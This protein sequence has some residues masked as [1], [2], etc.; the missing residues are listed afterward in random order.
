MRARIGSA[1]LALTLGLALLSAPAWGDDVE[2]VDDPLFDEEYPQELGASVPDPI[3]PLNRKFFVFNDKVD[4]YVLRPVTTAYQ[5]VVPAPIRA[6]VRRVFGNVKSPV[7]LVNNLFQLRFHD[8]AETLGSFLVNSTAGIGGIFDWSSKIGIE[9]HPADFGQTLGVFGV[10]SGPYLVIPLLG[11][12]TLR[13][14]VGDVVDRAFDPL[15]YLLGIGNLIFIGGSS[16]FV[17]R[18]ANAE[19]IEALRDSSVDYYAA[20]RSAYTQNR[21]SRIAELRADFCLAK[22]DPEPVAPE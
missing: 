1:G 8:A 4:Q 11:P 20:M 3:E 5:Y 12:S 13:D 15:T 16:G 6:G 22:K 7:Y 18:E 21:E 10:K 19:R 17:T 9:Q 2:I 14:G